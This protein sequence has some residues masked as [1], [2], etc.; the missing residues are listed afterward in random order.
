LNEKSETEFDGIFI[1]TEYSATKK[2]E[3]CQAECEN[4]HFS[5]PPRRQPSEEGP[6]NPLQ[7]GIREAKS[8]D[9]QGARRINL[10]DVGTS[11]TFMCMNEA[12]Q[13]LS[14]VASGDLHAASQLLPL[15][16]DE[17]RK[18]AAQRLAHEPVG[19]RQDATSLVHEA[20]TR[21]VGAD[22]KEAWTGRSHFFA[23]AAEAMRRI[24]IEKARRRARARHGGDIQRH[25]LDESHLAA[26]A[27]EQVLIVHDALD[28]LA[29]EDPE[30]A[31]VVKL[32]FFV[33]LKIHETADALGISVRT[34]NRHWEYARAWFSAQ[35]SG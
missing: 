6:Q 22:P 3:L 12:H 23:A 9:R 7:S 17:L 28:V 14:A 18:L 11:L 13:L 29:A 30:V 25:P 27:G 1:A 32:R 8:D 31:E 21:L 5:H 10:P 33:G 35:L 16:Y 26:D 15:V 20:Y 19:E 34:A 24:L 2:A 4:F